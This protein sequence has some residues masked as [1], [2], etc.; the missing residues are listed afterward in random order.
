M[1]L[2]MRPNGDQT[3]QKTLQSRRVE[4]P[5]YMILFDARQVSPLMMCVSI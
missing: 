5:C 1:S 2:Q 4:R 3:A